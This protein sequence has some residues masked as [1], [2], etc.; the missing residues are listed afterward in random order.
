MSTRKVVSTCNQCQA[1]MQSVADL[2]LLTSDIRPIL[3]ENQAVFSVSFANCK[4]AIIAKTKGLAVLVNEVNMHLH[5]VTARWE[6]VIHCIHH[7]CEHVVGLTENCAQAAYLIAISKKHCEPAVPGIVDRYQLSCANLNLEICCTRLK[8]SLKEE[9]TPP[10]LVDICSDMSK[11]LSVL[12]ECCRKASE[13]SS[14]TCNR[15]QFKLCIKSIT[16]C[17]SCLM[18]SI[19]TFKSQPTEAHHRRCGGFCDPLI[20]A[21]QA[22]VTFATEETF[23]GKPASL[24]SDAKEANQ[25]I[26]GKSF[27]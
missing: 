1:K 15:D 2:L 12:T 26:L 16:S 10:V 18:A 22:L 7:I 11:S 14:D 25:V 13:C 17:A 21:C 24:T 27:L 19:K 23:L 4:E 9:L 6:D 5:S 8:T 20:A 3:T